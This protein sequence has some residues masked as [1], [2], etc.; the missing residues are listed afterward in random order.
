MYATSVKRPSRANTGQT[1]LQTQIIGMM[2]QW[3][4]INMRISL[5]K[6]QWEQIG[7][8]AG[9]MEA[10]RDIDVIC[11]KCHHNLGKA[12]KLVQ[13]M[14]NITCPKCRT[15]FDNP[16]SLTQIVAKKTRPSRMKVAGGWGRFS[17]DLCD[18]LEAQVMMGFRNNKSEQEIFQTIKSIPNIVQDM[19]IEDMSDEDLTDCIRENYRMQA[20]LARRI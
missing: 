3:T 16:S 19:Q 13:I 18:Q 1:F 9:W 4:E 17:E 20:I 7:K 15:I 5:S 10:P 6:S 2:S 11:P 8:V 12:S 14:N